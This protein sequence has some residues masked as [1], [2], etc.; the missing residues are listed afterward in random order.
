MSVA[1][2]HFNARLTCLLR[3]VLDGG[4]SLITRHVPEA[5]PLLYSGGDVPLDVRPLPAPLRAVALPRTPRRE[6]RPAAL[7][8]ALPGWNMR[9]DAFA[10]LF[11]R[12]P[13]LRPRRPASLAAPGSRAGRAPRAPCG[14]R[15]GRGVR[16]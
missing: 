11:R 13:C 1:P 2:T 10:G 7:A 15:R 3:A 14:R 5:Q 6:V 9:C 8:D 16:A 12:H 4:V